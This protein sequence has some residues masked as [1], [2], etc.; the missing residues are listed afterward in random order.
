M[1]TSRPLKDLK[2][3]LN[4]GIAQRLFIFSPQNLP[5]FFSMFLRCSFHIKFLSSNISR[6]FMDSC[7][8]ILRLLI[9]KFG[10]QKRS[11]V[12]FTRFMEKMNT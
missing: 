5:N 11:I 12:C 10:S 6:Y 2:L 4:E 3:K 9:I 7:C 8:F 1:G